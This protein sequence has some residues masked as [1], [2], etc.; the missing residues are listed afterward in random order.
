MTILW[1]DILECHN[2]YSKGVFAVK[3]DKYLG[4]DKLPN[5]NVTAAHAEV[6]V[7]SFL[8]AAL[9]SDLRHCYIRIFAFP[10]KTEEDVLLDY[11]LWVGELTMEPPENW[12]EVVIYG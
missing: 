1:D 7:K 10:K 12:W 5:K 11:I 6:V 9:E 3:L 4:G 2:I 8:D